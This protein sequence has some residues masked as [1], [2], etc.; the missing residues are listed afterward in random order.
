MQPPWGCR[1]C[2]LRQPWAKLSPMLFYV[3]NWEALVSLHPAPTHLGQDVHVLFC[4]SHVGQQKHGTFQLFTEKLHSIC[5]CMR[6]FFQT[7]TDPESRYQSTTQLLVR[8]NK[9]HSAPI[10]PFFTGPSLGFSLLVPDP[11]GCLFS[12]SISYPLIDDDLLDA[13]VSFRVSHTVPST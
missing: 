11:P 1:R 2:S 3:P 5:H 6:G 9:A 13:S 10:L 8:D 7:I 12:A 4:G